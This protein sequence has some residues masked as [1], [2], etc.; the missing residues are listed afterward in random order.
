[1]GGKLTAWSVRALGE[2]FPVE[3]GFHGFFAQ[4]H[5][6]YDL[7]DRVGA[8]AN[9]APPPPLPD[10]TREQLLGALRPYFAA[11]QID[12][13]WDAINRMP[14][15]VLVTTL[16]MLCP[17]GTAEKQALLEA[18]TLSDR[19]ADDNPRQP[20]ASASAI[21]TARTTSLSVA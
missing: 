1:M 16:A 19:A 18:E 9:L 13:N 2:E 17:L 7:L 5:N 21:S 15:P 12:A 3:H 14:D 10:G 6:L 11:Q 20:S 8:T 4:Y